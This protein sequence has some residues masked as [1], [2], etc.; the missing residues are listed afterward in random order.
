MS[1]SLLYPLD[2]FYAAEGRALPA[3]GTVERHTVPEPFHTLLVHNGDMTPA[4]ESFHKSSIHLRVLKSSTRADRY[5][6]LVVLELD[7]GNQP[8]EFGAIAIHL[9][10]FD[11]AGRSEILA[12]RRPLGAVLREQK[13]AHSSHPEAFF[14]V[15]VDEWIA[16]ELRLPLGTVLYGRRNRLL[17]GDGKVLADV[18]EIVTPS[19][20]AASSANRY[21]GETPAVRD[22]KE[23]SMQRDWD[24][25][26]IG[27]GPAGATCSAI[28]AQNGRRVLVLEREKFPRYHIGES[29]LPFTYYPLKRTG[30]LEKMRASTFVKKFSVQ[31]VSRSGKAS[32]PFYFFTRYEQDVAQTWQVLR[33]EFDQ[34]LMEN[35]REKGATVLEEMHVR[36]LIQ[37]NERYV[38]VR[39]VDGKGETFEFR[40]PI[41]L[42]CTGRESFSASR[43][44]WRIQDPKLN[45]VA[46]WTYYKGAQRDP[47][48]DA[49]ATTVAYVPEKGWFWYIPQHNDMISVGVVADGKYLLRDGVRD[50]KAIFHREVELNTWIK[51]HLAVGQQVG[52]YYTTGEYS[53]R[54]KY[55]AADGLALVGDAYGFL[56]PIFSSGVMFA[57]K[58]GS[59]VADVVE[60]CFKKNDFSAKHFNEYGRTMMEGIE[61]MRA[62]VYAF[63]DQ[64]FSF[65]DLTNKYPETA[66]DVTDCLSGDVNK[67]FERLFKACR[68]FAELPEYLGY[69]EPLNSR[70]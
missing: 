5:L 9:E 3:I 50:P 13:V 51:E 6:R 41:T 53:F 46:C 64:N 28:L 2:D 43:H 12:G 11:A 29:L 55:C 8:I 69:G 23:I 44:N 18:V 10:H 36:E 1:H 27:C 30:M 57:L 68:E 49:G 39:G 67:S 62:L 17:T 22:T 47:G 65:R 37:D 52:E 33:S 38:G 58:S 63:Y 59:M 32:Q 66:G 45:K 48:I 26:V 34:M 60:E 56:D 54:S 40:A 61:N 15:R 31:F 7:G 25:I 16:R 42:D 20:G 14:T 4:L 19:A 21:A 35:A 24:V 70:G